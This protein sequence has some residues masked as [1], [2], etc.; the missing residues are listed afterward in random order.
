MAIPWTARGTRWSGG[1]SA[2]SDKSG[3]ILR[4]FAQYEFLNLAR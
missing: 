1:K 2:L 3:S 4:L